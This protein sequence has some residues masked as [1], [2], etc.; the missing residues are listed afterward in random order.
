ML[1]DGAHLNVNAKRALDTILGGEESPKEDEQRTDQEFAEWIR[2]TPIEDSTSDADYGEASRLIAKLY[3]MALEEG[4]EG[5]D[6][7]DVWLLVEERWPELAER[8]SGGTGFM[9]G[10]AFNAARHVLGL[11]QVQNPALLEIEI[12]EG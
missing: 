3:L 10:W 9:H 4:C 1:A 5:E 8:A 12:P 11:G 6:A 2:S 7:W